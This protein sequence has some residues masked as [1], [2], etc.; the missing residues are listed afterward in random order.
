MAH[1]SPDDLTTDD[2]AEGDT[3]EI[4]FHSKSHRM[5]VT[6]DFDVI[7]ITSDYQGNVEEM[8]VRYHSTG[9]V[10]RL[11]NTDDGTIMNNNRR[12]DLYELGYVH[13]YPLEQEGDAITDDDDMND[14]DSDRSDE[15]DSEGTDAFPIKINW[16]G[17]ARSKFRYRKVDA[18][19]NDG[20]EHG[21]ETA[22]TLDRLKTRVVVKSR[23]EGEALASMLKCMVNADYR[24]T[25][26]NHRKS[27]QRVLRE[28]ENSMPEPEPDEP[29]EPD[30]TEKDAIDAEAAREVVADELAD[31]LKRGLSPSQALDYW[32]T[33]DGTQTHGGFTQ[34]DWSEIR[35]RS[36]QAV[37]DSVSKAQAQLDESTSNTDQ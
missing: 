21:E 29:D 34:T 6:R 8:Q 7:E 15:T 20:G 2:V 25:T 19:V 28:L 35:D 1:I 24:W 30:E 4:R 23:D 31:L 27:Y 9:K 10:Y 12:G 37:S 33:Q 16:K 5:I 18:R 3:I 32:A 11:I 22:A 17:D 13:D 36:Q 26:E 14:E